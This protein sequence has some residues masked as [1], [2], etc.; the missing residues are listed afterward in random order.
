M[1]YKT[2]NLIITQSFNFSNIMFLLMQRQFSA[3]MIQLHPW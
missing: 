2:E 1:T 3:V